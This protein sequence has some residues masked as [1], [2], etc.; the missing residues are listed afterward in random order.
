MPVGTERLAPV[1]LAQ[2]DGGFGLDLTTIGLEFAQP[3]HQRSIIGP[4]NP[5]DDLAE[6]ASIMRMGVSRSTRR[7]N[8]SLGIVARASSTLNATP[9]RRRMTGEGVR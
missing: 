2:H 1:E 4:G 8:G 6:H 3:V 7:S 5:I 9:R